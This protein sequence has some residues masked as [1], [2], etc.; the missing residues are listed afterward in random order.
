MLSVKRYKYTSLSLRFVTICMKTRSVFRFVALVSFVSFMLFGCKKEQIL[1]SGG[2][3][4]FSVDT[5]MFDTVFT[6]LGSYTA[7]VKIYNPQN[8]AV[9]ISSVRLVD[10]DN[11]FFN[12]NVNGT[13]GNVV[14]DLEVAAKDSI[15][16]FA[17]VNID[18]TNANNPFIVQD[19]LIATLNGQEFSI[20]FVAYGQNAYYIVDSVLSTQ[21]W[22]TDKP[23]VIINNA[24]VDEGATLTLPAGCKVYVHANSRLYVV[25]TLNING[26]KGNEVVFQGDRLDRKYFGDEGYPGEWGGLYFTQE[27]TNNKINYAILK[28][29]GNSTSLNGGFVQPAAIQLVDTIIDPNDIQLDIRN[30]IIENSIGYGIL[31]FTSSIYAENCLI[32]NCGASALGI[33]RGGWYEFNNCNFIIY[34]DEKVSHIDN[35]TVG[36]FN[37]FPISDNSPREYGALRVILRNSIIWGSLEDELFTRGNN[38]LVDYDITLDHCLI[39][40]KDTIPT[41]VVKVNNILNQDPKFEN[42]SEWNFKPTAGSPLINTGVSVSGLNT[43][44]E[45]K[46]RDAQPD[47]GCYEF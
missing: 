40:M 28:N 3:L 41:A 39:K 38:D 45:G 31:S 10:G 4:Q 37:Y 1:S 12:L 9:K 26:T 11:S 25:G 19:D 44:I 2:Q 14:T 16:V 35:P 22:L 13:P 17:T 46:V 23:Y 15:Y 34:G 6:S 21:T 36:L 20:P 29:C 42:Y 18:P 47:I 7:S 5:L 27:S 33:F 24:Y 32:N 43:D 30:T 8:K